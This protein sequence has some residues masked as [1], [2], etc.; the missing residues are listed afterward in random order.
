MLL[1]SW[2][3]FPLITR[4][5]NQHEAAILDAAFAS[6]SDVDASIFNRADL[7]VLGSFESSNVLELIAVSVRVTAPTNHVYFPTLQ[8]SMPK[9]VCGGVSGNLE[10]AIG[11]QSTSSGSSSHFQP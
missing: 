1:S 10:F 8:V 2:R 6:T 5:D 4:C 9:S 11:N 7:N 3:V